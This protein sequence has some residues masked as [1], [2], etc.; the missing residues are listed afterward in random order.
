M[1]FVFETASNGGHGHDWPIW[2]AAYSIV[3]SV[4]FLLFA[5]IRLWQF[6][7]NGFKV[8]PNG[9]SHIK[10]VCLKT[11]NKRTLKNVECGP[12]YCIGLPSIATGQPRQ[13]LSCI[14]TSI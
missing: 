12:G 11:E 4:S 7:C 2:P 5:A 3:V 13:M 9:N 8:K 6:R 14:S 10:V 1:A